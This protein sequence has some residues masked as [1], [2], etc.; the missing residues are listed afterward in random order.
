MSMTERRTI[1]GSL[2]ALL[3]TPLVF[4]KDA[5]VPTLAPAGKSTD[6][7]PSLKITPPAHSV[8]RRG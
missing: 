4:G 3:A 1:L 7:E 6:P 2:M 5:V 8:K